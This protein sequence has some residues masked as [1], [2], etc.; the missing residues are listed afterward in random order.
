[1]WLEHCWQSRIIYI[2]LFSSFFIDEYLG[3]FCIL[4]RLNNTCYAHSCKN[5]MYYKPLYT[6]TLDMLFIKKRTDPRNIK[7]NK[8]ESWENQNMNWSIKESE[9]GIRSPRRVTWPNVFTAELLPNK[10]GLLQRR[11]KNTQVIL[12]Q[13]YL[14]YQSQMRTVPEKYVQISLT[15]TGSKTWGESPANLPLP[16]LLEFFQLS[17]LLW[18]VQNVQKVKC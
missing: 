15:D 6:C 12:R 2:P 11:G 17:C 4:A 7:A 13:H 8:S 5:K 18:N 10:E 9:W 1:M 14:N 16:R 3:C